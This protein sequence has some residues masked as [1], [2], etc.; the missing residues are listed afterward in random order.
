M[1]HTD[2]NH[3]RRSYRLKGYD[4]ASLGAYF[5]T[6]CTKDRR[7]LFD[8]PDIRAIAERCWLEIPQ[9]HGGAELD[10]W[11]IMPDHL[12]GIV[13]FTGE[14]VQLNAP[15]TTRDSTDS[16]ST[17]SPT[18]DSLGAVIR[19]FKAAV[20]TL[21][22]RGGNQE[23][24]WQRSYYDRVIRDEGELERTREYIEQNPLQP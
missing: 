11:V 3:T 16:Y 21:C 1:R 14:G 12:H 15:T 7:P 9:H 10:T 18:H 5:V 6:I 22:R 8:H 2:Q 4:Y 17:M 24:G 19:T 13:F 20:T 23:F